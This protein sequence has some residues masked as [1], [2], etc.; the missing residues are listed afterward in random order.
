MIKSVLKKI[1]T[2][3]SFEE[4]KTKD[5]LEAYPER[6]HVSAF[7]ERRYLKTSRFLTF[8]VVVSLLFNFALGFVYWRMASVIEASIYAPHPYTQL[9]RMDKM[10][11]RF[12]PIET[13]KVLMG[14][15][16]LVFE[17]LI[18]EYVT[19]L[20]SVGSDYNEVQ[21]RWN[22]GGIIQLYSSQALSKML[23]NY[24]QQIQ[25]VMQRRETQ[26]VYVY[27]IQY[28]HGN[29]FIVWYDVF[30]FP[31]SNLGINSCVCLE[32]DKECLKC[33]REN[34]F[35]VRRYKAYINADF[36][37]VMQS[38]TDAITNPFDF[39]VI[40]FIAYPQQIRPGNEWLDVDTL[41][42]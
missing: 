23:V 11:L 18:N 6:L 9:M 12:K 41:Q 21:K 42:Y 7:P 25:A 16:R 20:Y 19:A 17:N 5:H 29:T 4:E 27:A 33:Y 40:S 37:S 36:S 35:S 14:L 3:L 13:P 34:A 30:T 31:S 28:L 8:L 10:E 32:I 26:S 22:T 39:N 38:R 24:R 1:F 2:C 15:D